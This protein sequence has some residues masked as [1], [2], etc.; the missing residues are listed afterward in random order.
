MQATSPFTVSRPDAKTRFPVGAVLLPLAAAAVIVGIWAL[1]SASIVPNLPSPLKTWEASKPY[2]VEPFE[3]RGE[4]DQGAS[5]FERQL[6][7]GEAL[8]PREE[9]RGSEQGWELVCERALVELEVA[10]G[11]QT[12]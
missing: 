12:L 5:S 10:Q 8:Q 9:G 3:K 6:G 4:L 11:R 7:E 1:I 2:I